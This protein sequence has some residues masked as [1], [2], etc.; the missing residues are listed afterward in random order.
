MISGDLK[1]KRFPKL[2]RIL[3]GLFTDLAVSSKIYFQCLG[4]IFE[5]QRC[6]G[7]QNV[8][9]IDRFSFL[10]LTLLGCYGMLAYVELSRI[11]TQRTFAGDEADEL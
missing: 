8:F 3:D 7:K 9:A 10:L 5:S 4:I 11:Y 2:L 1:E 6:H